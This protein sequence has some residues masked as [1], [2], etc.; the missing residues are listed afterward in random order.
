MSIAVIDYG[1]GNLRSVERALV[2][3]GAPRVQV[4]DEPAVIDAA[5]RIV[6]PGQGAVRD[7]MSALHRH[8]LVDV[9]DR[10]MRDRPFLGIC[11]GMQALMTRSEENEGVQALGHFAGTV[12]HFRRLTGDDPRLK[13]PHMGWNRL[14]QVRSHPLFAGIADEVRFYFVHSYYVDP[15]DES[16][17]QG[18]SDYGASFAAAIGA[19]NVFAT[20]FHPEKS[21]QPGLR[22]LKNFLSWD[23]EPC[24]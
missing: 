4:T 11:M 19:A 10:V 2:H 7:C 14:H 18:R 5:E 9:L 22:L 21:Q 12:R 13:I 17:V 23:G 3:V 24:S 20:Q 15:D 8:E 16:I 6:F 1:M